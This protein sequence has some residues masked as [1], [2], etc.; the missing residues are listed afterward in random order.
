MSAAASLLSFPFWQVPGLCVHDCL[1]S[2]DLIYWF[3]SPWATWTKGKQ[4]L[5]QQL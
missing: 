4:L 2:L 5:E 3:G 1:H